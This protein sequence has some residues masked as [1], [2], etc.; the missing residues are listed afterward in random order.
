LLDEP[1]ELDR[2][3]IAWEELATD[4]LEPNVFYEPWMLLPALKAFGGSGGQQLVFALVLRGDP[5]AAPEQTRLCGFCPLQR[6]RLH[7]RLPLSILGLWQHVHCY[8]CTPLLRADCAGAALAALLD[9]LYAD[10]H[11]AALVQFNQ[12]LTTGPFS[13]CLEQCCQAHENPTAVLDSHERALFRPRGDGEHYLRSALTVKRRRAFERKERR[14]SEIGPLEYAAL[15][16]GGDIERWTEEFLR[17]EAAGWKGQTGTALACDAKDSQ[18][19]RAI[20]RAAFERDR[21]S[22]CARRLGGRPIAFRCRFLAGEGAFAFKMAYDEQYGDFSPG[23]LLEMQHLRRLHCVPGLRWM[24]SCTAADNRMMNQ[25][26]PC[27]RAVQTVLAATGPGPARSLVALY[28]CLRGLKRALT[29]SRRR[30]QLTLPSQKEMP[31][32]EFTC[33]P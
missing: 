27:R 18:Y 11:G 4:A 12:I 1:C 19:F 8:L 23:V 9:H 32:R 17:L 10:A 21:L 7:P 33:C 13:R 24:D 26:W 6:R 5:L 14:L 25:L 31:R 15:E 28:P 16:H 30:P 3:R 22:F 2:Y 29:P 20:V